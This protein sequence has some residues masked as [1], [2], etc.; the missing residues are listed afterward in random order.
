MISAGMLGCGGVLSRLE[1][2]RT[3]G[4]H[5]R[6][7]LTYD[8]LEMLSADD[9]CRDHLIA[10]SDALHGLPEVVVDDSMAARL[11]NGLSITAVRD[12]PLRRT[13]N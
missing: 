6:D 10:L 9:I 11:R 3:G 2:V 1:R 13:G 5:V 7:A 8:A 4:F 12:A